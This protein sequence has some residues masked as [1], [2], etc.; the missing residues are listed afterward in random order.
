MRRDDKYI[1]IPRWE[2][3]CLPILALCCVG[4]FTMRRWWGRAIHCLRSLEQV[5]R[6]GFELKKENCTQF[7]ML[8]TMDALMLDPTVSQLLVLPFFWRVTR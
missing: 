4:I 2:V 6:K 1:V 3:R 8:L 5:P 7:S